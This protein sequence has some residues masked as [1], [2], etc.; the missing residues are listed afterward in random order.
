MDNNENK[1]TPETSRN[2]VDYESIA[3]EE[4]ERRRQQREEPERAFESRSGKNEKGSELYDWIQCLVSAIIFCV[5]V[6]SFFVRIIGVVGSSMEPTFSNGDRVIIS[7]LFYE[8]KQGDVVVLRKESFQEE[9][10]IKRVIATEGQTIGIDFETGTVYV[11]DVAIEE[12]YIA[13]LTREPLDFNGK[14]LVPENCVFVMG[15]NRNSSTDSRRASIGC[16]DERYIIGRVLI[17]LL[18]LGRFGVVD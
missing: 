18:P 4:L 12:P 2:G 3:R 15:D 17:R 14:V 8:P 6:F 16:V 7:G 1:Y 13:E 9:P 10:I 11:D 5:L